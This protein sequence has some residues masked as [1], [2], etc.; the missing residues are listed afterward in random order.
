MSDLVSD[1]DKVE[2]SLLIA[3]FE[4]KNENKIK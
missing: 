2:S 4:K 1:E 3:E